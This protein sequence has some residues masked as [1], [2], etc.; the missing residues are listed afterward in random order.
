MQAQ[1]FLDGPWAAPSLQTNCRGKSAGAL[2]SSAERPLQPGALIPVHRGK[3]GCSC[4]HRIL[5]GRK[6]PGGQLV[7][8]EKF[9]GKGAHGPF[10]PHTFRVSSQHIGAGTQI[11]QAQLSPLIQNGNPPGP[12]KPAGGQRACH[13]PQNRGLAAGG[14][15]CHQN[16]FLPGDSFLKQPVR[17][18]P[19]FPGNAEHQGGDLPHAL[20]AVFSSTAVP[21]S[22]TRKTPPRLT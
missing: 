3:Q 1:N 19:H 7:T 14:W 20:H 18:S 15:A 4:G 6:I 2:E 5:Y 13:I 12:S 21:Q 9:R 11:K 8:Q 16:P 17:T 22:P 10:N